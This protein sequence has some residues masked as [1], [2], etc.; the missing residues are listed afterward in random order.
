MT[1]WIAEE[2]L[3]AVQKTGEV[4]ALDVRIGK[5]V[6]I[7]AHEWKCSVSLQGLYGELHDVH[8][9]TSLQALCLTAS[10][11]RRLL[12]H[13]V[14]DG[15]QLRHRGTNEPFDIGASFGNVGGDLPTAQE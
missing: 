7:S 10:L 9:T 14:Q 12:S 1:D 5:P 11:A 4:F 2:A 15:G 13:F 8:G 3:D 6:Q